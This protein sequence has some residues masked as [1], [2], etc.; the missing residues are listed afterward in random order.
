MNVKSPKKRFESPRHSKQGGMSFLRSVPPPPNN[1]IPKSH[2]GAEQNNQLQFNQTNDRMFSPISE[3]NYFNISIDQ[4]DFVPSR[5]QSDTNEDL[6]DI[7]YSDPN[8]LLENDPTT[9][10]A[11]NVPENT[12]IHQVDIQEIKI[13][14]KN[15]S[16]NN[17]PIKL[18]NR[19]GKLYRTEVSPE[20]INSH[21]LKP[22]VDAWSKEA[23]GGESAEKARTTQLNRFLRF[24]VAY[25]IQYPVSIH[26]S[27]YIEEL[28]NDPLISSN[29]DYY[30]SAVGRF[31]KWA[32][33]ESK[34]PN[35]VV[36]LINDLDLNN[37]EINNESANI[38]KATIETSKLTGALNAWINTLERDPAIRTNSRC[39]ITN[40]I[41]YL[42]Q[43]HVIN[44]TTQNIVAYYQ[45]NR[46]K[47]AEIIEKF[48]SWIEEHG[49]GNNITLNIENNL[50]PI[51]RLNIEKRKRQI[52]QQ[53]EQ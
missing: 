24:L 6:F 39:E 37:P 20:Q 32:A 34:Y 19:R 25:S 11:N 50:S 48:F 52:E 13:V 53:R 12:P 43:K 18:S 51:Q 46:V 29:K 26:I 16:I 4:D 22:L 38:N 33:H 36:N 31:F 30:I 7:L 1:M 27:Q 14:H 45:T 2:V 15:N 49:I 3:K 35:I 17:K 40:L 9:E 44:A 21:P 41:L 5:W 28:S 8:L 10:N 23:N 47:D 42:T